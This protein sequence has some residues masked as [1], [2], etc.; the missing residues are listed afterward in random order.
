MDR[1]PKLSRK[2]EGDKII[3]TMIAEKEVDVDELFRNAN[4]AKNLIIEGV[5]HMQRIPKDLKERAELYN[6][7]IEA[8]E[9][10]KKVDKDLDV[11]NKID[12]KKKLTLDMFDKPI[13]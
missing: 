3:R 13:E 11:P 1:V 2:K 10:I 12:T 4:T 5:E 7:T 8:L 6:T 9:G